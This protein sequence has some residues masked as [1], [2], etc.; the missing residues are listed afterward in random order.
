[1]HI[2]AFFMKK[3]GKD[4]HFEPLNDDNHGTV[5]NEWA[6]DITDRI[7][8]SKASNRLSRVQF[9]MYTLLKNYTVA[10]VARLLELPYS[11]MYLK[12]RKIHEKMRRVME[13]SV[14]VIKRGMNMNDLSQLE[15]LTAKEVSALS[16]VDL[17]DLNEQITK[18]SADLKNM[19]EK[20]DDGMNIKFRNSVI[21]G[22]QMAGKDT[23]TLRFFKDEIMVVAEVPK[24]VTWDMKK[25]EELVK[26]IPDNQRKD[27][28]KISYAIDERKYSAL[29]REYQEVLKDARTVTPGKIRY[30]FSIGEDI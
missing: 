13:S 27:I 15:T 1:M 25:M 8:L 12:M 4:V 9:Q 2:R 22:L 23:G 24:K 19:K 16:E 30:Q 11:S 21:K 7:D 17:M 18:L 3:N 10:D 6:N 20:L 5:D 28:V 26:L 29:P 14:L